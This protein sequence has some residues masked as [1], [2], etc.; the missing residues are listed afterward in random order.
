M[1]HHH[2]GEE[3]SEIGIHTQQ[4]QQTAKAGWR[5]RRNPCK[6]DEGVVESSCTSW[7]ERNQN[8]H[9]YSGQVKF[10]S[11]LIQNWFMETAKAIT[12]LNLNCT[13]WTRMDQSSWRPTKYHLY[14]ALSITCEFSVK[15]SNIT[16]WTI[17][18]DQ[19]RF[20]FIFTNLWNKSGMPHHSQC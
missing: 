11:R 7:V 14:T 8:V 16:E 2:L 1:H 18:H 5:R 4:R 10:E 15:G 12:L 9:V 13:I 17:N 3:N 20:K 19:A 6:G